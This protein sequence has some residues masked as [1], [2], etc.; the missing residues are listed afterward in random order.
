MSSD[1]WLLVQIFVRITKE[2]LRQYLRVKVY[3]TPQAN[4]ARRLD[5][6][7]RRTAGQN[8]L[9]F[10]RTHLGASPMGDGDFQVYER[11]PTCAATPLVRQITPYRH[12]GDALL[13]KR[14]PSSDRRWHS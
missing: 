9:T 12:C 13:L 3:V 11:R 14:L 5:Q 2:A 8:P 1:P 4:A 6:A 10:Y 7:A